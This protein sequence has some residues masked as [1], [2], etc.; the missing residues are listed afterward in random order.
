VIGKVTLDDADMRARLRPLRRGQDY[1]PRTQPMHSRKLFQD[2]QEVDTAQVLAKIQQMQSHDS[3]PEPVVSSYQQP[4]LAA[5][6]QAQPS[7]T[8]RT[9]TPP[10]PP[11]N[12]FQRRW[13][14]LLARIRPM[15]QQKSSRQLALNSVASLVLVVGLSVSFFQVLHNLNGQAKA[16]QASVAGAVPATTTNS[17]N[18]APSTAIVNNDTLR[19]YQVAPDAARFIRITKLGVLARVLQ[20]GK[21]STGA[22]ATPSN[23]FDTAWY[24]GSAKPGQP[25]ATLI[26]G[27]VSSWTTNGVFYGIKNLV[28]GDNIEIE[29]GDGSKLEYSVVKTVSYPVDSVDMNA[30]QQPVTAGQSGLNLITCGGKYDSKSGEFTQRIAV[31]ATLNN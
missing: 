15:L 30:L 21:T 12:V 13:S 6:P 11:P 24:K 27:H 26:D 28:A 25:G 4:T 23:V 29:K 14:A 5:L 10:V 7:L 9:F 16:A 19:S 18:T 20:V 31:F 1:V 3:A 2:V 22:L 8:P 17:T